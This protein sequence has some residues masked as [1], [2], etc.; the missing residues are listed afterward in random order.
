V[1]VTGGY[2]ELREGDLTLRRQME[3][4]ASALI[5]AGI[6]PMAVADRVIAAIRR[7]DPYVFTHGETVRAFQKRAEG[8]ARAGDRLREP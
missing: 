3:E 7:Y 2:G 6:D 5:G 1:Q 8:I 4:G